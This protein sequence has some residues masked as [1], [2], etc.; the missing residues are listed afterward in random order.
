M[1]MPNPVSQVLK[2]LRSTNGATWHRPAW[3]SRKIWPFAA[4]GLSLVAIVSLLVIPAAVTIHAQS[5]A[6]DTIFIGEIL[7][8]DRSHPDRK[9]VV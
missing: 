4:C 6:A 8:L 1:D 5:P 9:S 3:T 7:T 2:S